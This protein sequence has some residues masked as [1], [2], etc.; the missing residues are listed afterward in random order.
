M[1]KIELYSLKTL[2]YVLHTQN[3]AFEV[4][5]FIDDDEEMVLLK[6]EE[7]ILLLSVSKTPHEQNFIT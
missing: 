7:Q 5:V 1:K 3:W 6:D 2:Q 4:V